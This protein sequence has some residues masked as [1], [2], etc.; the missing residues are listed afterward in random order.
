MKV[1]LSHPTGNRNVRAVMTGLANADMLAGFNTTLVADPDALWIKLLPNNLRKEWLRRSFPVSKSKIHTRPVIE[2]ARIIMPKLG[3]KNCIEHEK[4]WASIDAVYHDLDRN[5]AKQLATNKLKPDAVYAYED[6]ALETFKQAKILGIKCIYDLPIAYWKT[7][8]QLM[9]QEAERLP[10]WAPTLGGGIHDSAAKLERK[11]QEFELADV[12]VGPGSFVMDSLPAYTNKKLIVSPFGSPE[13]DKTC[14]E[15][16]IGLKSTNKPL[17]VLFAGSMGQRK[18]LADLFTAIKKIN[19]KNVELVVMGSLLAPAEFYRN[20]LADFTY[21]AGRPNEKVL[22]LMRSCD[23]FCLPSIVEGRALV[24]QEAM[25]QGLPL[26]ITPNTGGA[27]LIEEGETGF[28]VPTCSP[29]IIAEKISWFMDNRNRVA[30]MG[31]KAMKKA[32]GYTWDAYGNRI[33][34]SITQYFE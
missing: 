8:K 5:T 24:M 12:V 19:S 23:V 27:D 9:N 7:V 2:L 16:S 25:S 3:Y 32:T 10:Q 30:E 6:G 31:R 1:I 20:E 21:E 22:E 17:R 14:D 15:S 33:A 26:I 29:E 13:F 18:G 34:Q 4:G 28:L 11:T